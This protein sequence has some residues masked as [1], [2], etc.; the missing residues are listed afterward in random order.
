MGTCGARGRVGEAG[1]GVDW[2]WGVAGI[3]AEWGRGK[4]MS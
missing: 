2:G 4:G 1:V 3:G